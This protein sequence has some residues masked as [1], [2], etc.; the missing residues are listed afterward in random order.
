MSFKITPSLLA[1]SQTKCAN[2]LIFDFFDVVNYG[3]SGEKLSNLFSNVLLGE[4]ADLID[5]CQRFKIDNKIKYKQYL[6]EEFAFADI[7]NKIEKYK[8]AKSMGDVLRDL[9]KRVEEKFQ[10]TLEKM[11][12]MSYLKERNINAQMFD[13]LEEN[14]KL[15]GRYGCEDAD[16]Y[17]KSLKLLLSYVEVSTVPTFVDGVMIGSASESYFGEMKVLYILGGQALPASSKDN[18]LLSDDDIG[19]FVHEIEPTIKMINRRARFKLFNLLTL[20]EDGI[21]ITYQNLSEDGKKNS[22][23][24]YITSLNDIFSIFPVRASNVFFVSDSNNLQLALL[25]AEKDKKEFDYTFDT[26]EK[27]KIDAKNLYFP[28]NEIKVTELESYFNCPFSHFVNYGLKLKEFQLE[29]VDQRD[30][31]NI[32]HKNC[33]MYIRKL[34][35]GNFTS[36]I[37]H[38]KFVDENFEYILKDLNLVEK[39]QHLDEKESFFRYIKRQMMSNLHDIDRELEKSA[40]R[41]KFVEHK[42][43]D[44]KIEVNGNVFNLVGRVDRIDEKDDYFRIIDYKTGA[45][46]GVLKGLFY[47]EKLQLFLYQKIASKVLNKISAGGYYFN[48]K[49]EYANDEDDKFILKGIAP[50]DE[51]ILSY[52]DSDIELLNKSTIHSI[53]KASNG[54]YKGAGVTKYDFN[55]LSDYSLKL[56]NKGISEIIEGYVEPKPTSFS[57]TYCKLRALCRY[58]SS[59]GIRKNDKSRINF[60]SEE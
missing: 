2:G 35:K 40:F 59:Q 8:D 22:L 47:G 17:E 49:L 51:Q 1:F 31:G 21:I 6:E 45:V 53:A 10:E 19:R 9:L 4:N 33:E 52:L 16:E 12:E 25:S 18:G 43:N 56:V 55:S 27:L 24:A 28:T 26:R 38:K 36:K 57:C 29:D 3:Y 44:Y 32:C 42:F 30:V 15:I 23:P 7:L 5:K 37:D 14:I 50:S 11:E 41:P 46:G 60:K 34:I 48:A 54:G 39:I 20:A 58:E 13:I